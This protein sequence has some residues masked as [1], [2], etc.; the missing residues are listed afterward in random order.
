MPSALMY[1]TGYFCMRPWKKRWTVPPTGD[2]GRGGK[3]SFYRRPI[4][5]KQHFPSTCDPQ[6][7]DM[8]FVNGPLPLKEKVAYESQ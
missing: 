2:S 7:L 3:V 1:V 6:K 4:R 5:G 8:G